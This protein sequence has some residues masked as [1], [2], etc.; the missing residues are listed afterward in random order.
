MATILYSFDRAFLLKW[1][2]FLILIDI[3]FCYTFLETASHESLYVLQKYNVSRIF[4][5]FYK[6]RRSLTDTD[7]EDLLEYQELNN[8]EAFFI[9]FFFAAVFVGEH[10]GW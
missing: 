8:F 9:S 4:T 2:G 5:N 7:M 6:M 1:I 3:Y 10:I